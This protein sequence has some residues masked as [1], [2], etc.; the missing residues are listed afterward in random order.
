M[1]Q[2]GRRDLPEIILGDERVPMI[3]QRTRRCASI[4]ILR[5][6]PLVD[7]AA[8]DRVEEVGRDPG[9]KD[10]PTT[11]RERVMSRGSGRA[12]GSASIVSG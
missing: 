9:F 6:R 12:A 1:V 3:L 2:P 11:L 5:K 4:L 7:D 8:V 10:E